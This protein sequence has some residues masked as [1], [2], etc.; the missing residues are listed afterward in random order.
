MKNIFHLFL[1]AF[2]ISNC[3]NEIKNKD[4]KVVVEQGT[5]ISK[6]EQLEEPEE[7]IPEVTTST[8]DLLGFW[9]GNFIPDH[10]DND[11]DKSLFIDDGY[12]WSRTNKINISIDKIT[13]SLVAGHSVVA[14]N[15]RP[16]EGTIEKLENP[17]RFFFK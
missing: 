13:D 11:D 7:K 8:Q 3:G 15:D 17:E 2:L 5:E 1:L 6:E 10:N 14:G 9:V 12:M 4:A 16:F